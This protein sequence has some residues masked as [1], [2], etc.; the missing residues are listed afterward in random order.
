MNPP[1]LPRP[2]GG[3]AVKVCGLTRPRDAELAARLGAAALG[4]VLAASPRQVDIRRA[5][6]IF[7][8][9]SPAPARVGVF[10]DPDPSFVA[11]AAIALDLDWIQLSGQ[12]PPGAAL[13]ILDA[14]HT[15]RAGD[16]SGPA[17][18]LIKAIH[19]RSAGAIAAHADYPAHVFL[20]DAPPVVA[21]GGTRMGGTGRVFDWAEAATLPWDRDRVALAGGLTAD[22]VRAAARAVR[23]AMVDV[24]SGVESAPGIKDPARLATF[25]DA[26]RRIE[27]ETETA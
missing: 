6:A 21:G 10:V 8:A 27:L 18:G 14:V 20:L 24:S 3:V 5:R 26:A 22:N 4:V 23:P 19:V 12:E 17:T 16:G 11:E 9:A 15:A 25:L 1:R 2:D 7:A 13:A